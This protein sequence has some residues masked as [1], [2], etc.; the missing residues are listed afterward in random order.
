MG[1]PVDVDSD[2]AAL[3]LLDPHFVVVATGDFPVLSTPEEA[4]LPRGL[5]DG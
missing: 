2:L 3:F 1:P 4:L 5:C